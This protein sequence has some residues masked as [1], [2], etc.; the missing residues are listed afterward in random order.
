MYECSRRRAE[1]LHRDLKSSRR[2]RSCRNRVRRYFFG[3]SG[4]VFFSTPEKSR[5]EATPTRG[6]L[7]ERP[8]TFPRGP[9]RPHLDA[10]VRRRRQHCL[11]ISLNPPW[12]PKPRRTE[13]YPCP[14]LP[15]VQVDTAPIPDRVVQVKNYQPW[16]QRFV[17]IHTFPSLRR[18]PSQQEPLHPTVDKAQQPRTDPHPS[19]FTMKIHKAV[20]RST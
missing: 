13:R 17:H 6:R 14:P 5:G 2:R 20:R 8:R 10:S 7:P 1:R 19:F 12:P 11:S 9:Q 16:T 3:D 15:D 4:N 18:R